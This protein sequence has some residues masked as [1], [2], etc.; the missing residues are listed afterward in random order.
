MTQS[1]GFIEKHGLWSDDQRHQAGEIAA[2]LEREDIR[3]VRLAWSDPHGASRAKMVTAQAF[4][5]ALKGGYNINVATAMLD[6]SGARVFSSFTRGGGL[7]LE[8]MTGSPNLI[9]VPDPAT[10]RVLPWEPDVGWVLCDDYFSSGR[11]FH[12]SPRHLLRKQLAR[13]QQRSMRCVVGLEVEWYLLRL[14]E[15][16]LTD[17]HIGAPGIK[18]RAVRAHPPEP[19]YSFHSETNLDRMHGPLSAL[20]RAFAKLDLPVRSFENEWGPGQVE[21]TFAPAEALQAAD[22]MVLFRSATRQ[23]CRRMGYLAS[24]MCRPKLKGLYPSGWHLHQSLVDVGNGS[25]LFAP[26]SA[27]ACLSPVGRA[28]VGGVLHHGLA[29]TIFANPTVNAYRRFRANSLAPDR[30]AWGT[31]HRGVMLR[32]LGEVGD[33][34]SRIENRIGEPAANPYL[35]IASQIITGLDGIDCA[36]DPGPPDT[37]PYNAERA[38]LPKSLLA[39]LHALEGEPLFR[40]EMGDLFVDYYLAFK[41]VEAGRFMEFARQNDLDPS[42]DEITDWEQN[43]YFDFF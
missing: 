38:K 42:S 10:F 36:R 33:P 29:A 43:E 8:E 9:V 37:D 26:Q 39:A 1:A 31:D 27:D 34:A 28:Y 41:R 3:L 15:E 18:G 11:P 40:R 25:N 5:S 14:S 7:G 21:C 12:F 22:N 4:L 24:F 6:A 32:V 2:R 20:A 16:H 30:L 13:L 23:L 17:E 35:Y 19:G